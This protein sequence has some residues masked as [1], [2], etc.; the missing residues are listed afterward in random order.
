MARDKYGHY[1]NDKGVE[2]KASTSSSGKDKIDFYDGCAAEEHDS[3]H[4]NYDSNTG[5]GTITDT[6][7]GSKTT[8]DVKCYLT[9]A[10]IK[11]FQE[12]FDDNC[13]ELRVL[14]WFRDN[15][16]SKDDIEMYYEVAPQIVEGIE[17][18]PKS[19]I[20]YDY[21]F[22]NVVD[23][24]VSAIEEG[25]YEFAYSRY[26]NSILALQNQF[27]KKAPRLSLVNYSN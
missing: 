23:A 1:V 4:I 17:A 15:F 8:T 25:N 26:K 21:I 13:Y 18:E 3:I 6:T 7:D 10:C 11:Y 20:V 16:V 14:R 22:E 12:N 5:K 2:I 27:A 9:T 24:C 19:D